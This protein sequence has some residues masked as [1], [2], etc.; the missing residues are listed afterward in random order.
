[1]F[2]FFNL[3]IKKAKRVIATII[4]AIFQLI[5]IPKYYQYI[6]KS[7]SHYAFIEILMDSLSANTIQPQY[8]V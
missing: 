8:S 4:H 2:P 1:M 3:K 5:K 7:A 6:C